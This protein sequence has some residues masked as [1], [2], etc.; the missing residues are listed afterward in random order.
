MK[1]EGGEDE[2]QISLANR[3]RYLLN[4]LL[5]RNPFWQI[6]VLV[7]VSA[8]IVLIGMLLVE[9]LTS[10]SFWWSFTRLVDQ[11]TFIND[12]YD[13]QVAAV[14][15]AVTVGGILILSLLIGIFSSKINE[16]LDSLKRGKSPVIEKGHFVVCGS[17]DRLFEVT[18]ELIRA[19]EQD[20]IHGRIVMFSRLS[21]EEMEEKVEQRLGRR[22]V[23]KVICRS[24]STTD[25]DALQIACFSRCRGFVV[26]GDDDGRILK[27][28]VGIDAIREANRPVGVC[29]LRNR[30]RHRIAQMAYSGIH[31]IPV[32]E[33]VMRLIVQVCR[34][35]GL[36]SVYNEILSFAGNEFYLKGFPEMEGL[37]FGEISGRIR[38]GVAVGMQSGEEMLLNPPAGKVLEK[39]SRLLI[40]TRDSESCSF[41]ES[42]E[43][44]EETVQRRG[45]SCRKPLKMLI[46]SGGSRQDR[47][48]VV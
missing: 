48:S 3:V 2:K 15:V 20:S 7:C 26:V 22:K 27:T 10:N 21:R 35:P 25:V 6:M 12:N 33:I 30:R 17:G 37:A 1:P 11:G 41:I 42:C 38:G 28:L 36:S 9:D 24:G 18:R 39:D 34:Q 31:W 44:N 29:E 43:I 13:P 4:T 46:L 23:R 45:E 14:G 32:R 5:L 19:S 8:V 47:K 16:K 40:L